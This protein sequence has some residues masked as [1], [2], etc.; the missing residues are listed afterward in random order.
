VYIPICMI[1]TS[2]LQRKLLNQ[3]HRL[4][5]LYNFILGSSDLLNQTDRLCVLYNFI[6]GLGNKRN[7]TYFNFLVDLNDFVMI[8]VM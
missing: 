3:T 2:Y 7:F 6:L 5:M 8:Y 1:R 4:C